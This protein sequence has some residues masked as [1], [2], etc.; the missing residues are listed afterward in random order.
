MDE[1]MILSDD[2]YDN[3]QDI[4]EIPNRLIDEAYNKRLINFQSIKP[5]ESYVEKDP[6]KLTKTRGWRKD[7]YRT[8]QNPFYI[9]P[10]MY[11]PIQLDKAMESYKEILKK[12]DVIVIIGADS[13]STLH[14]TR[15]ENLGKKLELTVISCSKRK[16]VGIDSKDSHWDVDF[17]S[18]DVVNVLNE[19][20]NDYKIGARF[21]YIVDYV[22]LGTPF[23]PNIPKSTATSETY[24]L[25]LELVKTTRVIGLILSPFSSVLK[26][27]TSGYLEWIRT[28]GHEDKHIANNLTTGYLQNHQNPLWV[29]SEYMHHQSIPKKTIEPYRNQTKRYTEKNQFLFVGKK[30]FYEQLVQVNIAKERGAVPLYPGGSDLF[31]EINNF[32]LTILYTYPLVKIIMD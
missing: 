5:T 6:R 21:L 3:D 17:D 28:P 11:T 25:F 29:A 13:Q 20:M 1:R 24:H 22:H 14:K 23:D 8:Y 2:D 31:F 18:T 10:H 19:K 7:V 26:K 30:D 16:M 12:D 27:L 9:R 32:S 4:D 15:M